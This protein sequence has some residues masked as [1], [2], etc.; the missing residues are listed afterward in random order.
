MAGNEER[1]CSVCVLLLDLSKVKGGA[2]KPCGLMQP[3]DVSE[4]KWNNISMDFVT[5][6]PN[7][8][9]GNDVIWV[10]VDRLSKSSHFIPIR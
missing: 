5:G 6:L 8:A 4:W 7:T 9:K 2:P 3:L 10:V 1:H